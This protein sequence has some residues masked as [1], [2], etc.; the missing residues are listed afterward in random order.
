MF[1]AVHVVKS[2]GL[3][4]LSGPTNPFFSCSCFLLTFF[5]LLSCHIFVK[6]KCN[7]FIPQM[8]RSPFRGPS[9]YFP[10]RNKNRCDCDV[11]HCGGKQETGSH[12]AKSTIQTH[13]NA[14]CA[15]QTDICRADRDK[16]ASFRRTESQETIF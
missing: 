15:T 14:E 8:Y 12:T 4:V 2:V 16:Q 7:L 1:Q 10:S 11:I 9:I 5:L 6:K 3:N 13:S